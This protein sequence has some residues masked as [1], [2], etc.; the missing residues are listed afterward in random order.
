MPEKLGLVL[1]M[2]I[3]RTKLGAR[4]RGTNDEETANRDRYGVLISSWNRLSA[5]K[6]G[7]L[8]GT[9]T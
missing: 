2:P 1:V 3:V 5:C 9:G 8:E 4:Q 6:Q 7:D